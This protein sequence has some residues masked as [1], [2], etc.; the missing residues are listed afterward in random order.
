MPATGHAPQILRKDLLE[1]KK[2][3]DWPELNG[4]A[5]RIKVKRKWRQS[6]ANA[7]REFI[8]ISDNST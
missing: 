1:D 3:A 4:D 6:E 2:R 7:L 5:T 8:R